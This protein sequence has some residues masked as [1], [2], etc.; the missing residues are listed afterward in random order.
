MS[1]GKRAGVDY[2]RSL[3]ETSFDQL[4]PLPILAS[5]RTHEHAHHHEEE[6]RRHE[7][8]DGRENHIRR[9]ALRSPR[10]YAEN[11]SSAAKPEAYEWKKESREWGEFGGSVRDTNDPEAGRHNGDAQEEPIC[12]ACSLRGRPG[13]RF[14]LHSKWALRSMHRS[15]TDE[16]PNVKHQRARATASRGIDE[17]SL[18]ALRCMR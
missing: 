2:G 1:R 12:L 13:D 15:P 14:E 16:P 11:D 10:L 4:R 3:V 9:G 7:G 6:E 5:R 17:L 18:R 8:N